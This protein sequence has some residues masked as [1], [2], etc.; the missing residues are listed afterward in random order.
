MRKLARPVGL[1]AILA[2]SIG[3]ARGAEA[4]PAAALVLEASG[5]TRPAIQPYT[6]IRT[7]TT[8]ELGP[9]ARIV[10]N[11]YLTCHRLVVTGGSVTVTPEGF[12]TSPGSATTEERR[13]CP[14]TVRLPAGGQAATAVMRGLAP[15]VVLA[16]QPAFVLV[17]PRAEEFAAVRVVRGTTVVLEAPLAGPRFEWPAGMAALAANTEYELSLVPKGGGSPTTFRFTATAAGDPAT[18]SPVLIQVE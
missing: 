5:S 6:E 1:L 10:L 13:P 12:V 15:R 14:K 7:G 8:I 3:L 4:Q 16:V 2:A 17:G 9:G 11:H 18:E